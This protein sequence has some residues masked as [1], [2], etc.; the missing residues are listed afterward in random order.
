M[1][2]SLMKQHDFSSLLHKFLNVNS[3][4]TSRFLPVVSQSPLFSMEGLGEVFGKGGFFIL[5]LNVQLGGKE[6]TTAAEKMTETT[7]TTEPSTKATFRPLH[8]KPVGSSYDGV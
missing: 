8:T 7:T 6:A 3:S 2:F 4:V 1:N 5:I